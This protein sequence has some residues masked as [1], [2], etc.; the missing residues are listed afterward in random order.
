MTGS[1]KKLIEAAL[2]LDA[3][4]AASRREKLIRNGHPSTLHLW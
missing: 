2:P 1:R 3:I 4:N